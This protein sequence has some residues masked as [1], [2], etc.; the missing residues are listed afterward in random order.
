MS[1]TLAQRI[2]AACKRKEP[3]PTA[4]DAEHARLQY[5]QRYQVQLYVYACPWE[6]HFHLTR[7]P[8]R[9]TR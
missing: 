1:H 9:R 4:P 5:Q 3:Y 6:A 2:N 8:Q 7:Q